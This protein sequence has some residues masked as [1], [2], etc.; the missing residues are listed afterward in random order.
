V[1]L[2]AKA[3][4]LQQ[5]RARLVTATDRERRRIERNLHDGAQQRLVAAAIQARVAHRLL[6]TSPEQASAGLARLAGELQDAAGELRDL[7]HGIY[8]PQLTE[9]GLEA[10]LRAAAARSPLPTTV[11]AAGLGRY[12]PEIEGSVYFCCLEALQNAIKHAGERAAV[13]ITV[14]DRDGLS[15]DVRDTGAGCRPEA[16]H[17]GHGFTNMSDRLGAVGGTLAIHTQ[18]GTGLHLHGHIDRPVAIGDVVDG[19]S[20]VSAWA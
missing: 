3:Q 12:P 18:P 10:A 5:S 7:A 17:A 16:I 8:P 13:T 9:H 1:S 6:A 20:D 11:H 14:Q 2:S 15:F 19:S 4:A